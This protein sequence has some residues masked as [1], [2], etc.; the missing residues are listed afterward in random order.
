[1]NDHIIQVEQLLDKKK[2]K[3]ALL[4]LQKINKRHPSFASIS[5][6]ASCYFFNNKYAQANL[7]FLKALPLTL[8]DTQ[9][10]EILSNLAITESKLNNLNKAIEYYITLLAIDGSLSTA[11][12]RNSLCT[13]AALEKNHKIVFEYAPKL[14]MLVEYAKTALY[15]LFQ[16]NLLINDNEKNIYLYFNKIIAEISSF[17]SSDALSFFELILTSNNRTYINKCL[18]VLSTK[19]SHEKWF[20]EYLSQENKQHDVIRPLIELPKEQVISCDSERVELVNEL[21][22]HNKLLGAKFHPNLRIFED[23]GNFSVKVYNQEN[24]TDKL[25]DIPHTCMPLLSDFHFKLDNKGDL[26]ATPIEKPIN[27]KAIGTMLLMQKIYNSC[28]KINH[29]KD[30]FP[31]IALQAFPH[32]LKKLVS[33][34]PQSKKI[35]CYNQ[36]LDNK[37]YDE[38]VIKSFLGSRDFSFEQKELKKNG[39]ITSKKIESGLLSVIDFLNHKTASNYYQSSDGSTSISGLSDP[40]TQE[41]FVHYNNFDPLLTYLIYGFVDLSSPYIFSVP[42]ELSLLNGQRIEVLGN[43]NII[44]EDS[45]PDNIKHLREYLTEVYTQSNGGLQVDKIMIPNTNESHLLRDI[46]TIMVN[47]INPKDSNIKDFSLQQEILH[48]EAQIISKNMNYWQGVQNILETIKV[49]GTTQKNFALQEVQLLINFFKSHY[50]KYSS[51]LGVSMF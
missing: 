16:S 28:N 2:Y 38:L 3:K 36:L 13:I 18:D 40:I 24:K 45:I 6:T 10:I 11:C 34:K 17:K 30:T 42:I 31:F 27:P 51:K 32:L 49:E 5:Y 12:H 43:T 20:K 26:L 35:E 9:K 25:I 21:L 14:L 50:Q 7:Y 46:L 8:N 23:K 19:F 29:W 15:L 1:M 47:T 33:A 44:K 48:L 4:I 41:L 22:K 39:I 37:K